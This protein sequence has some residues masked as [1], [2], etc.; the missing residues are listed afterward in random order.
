MDLFSPDPAANFLPHDGVVNDYGRLLDG[1]DADFYFDRLF[2]TIPW[3]HDE[4]V[5]FGK[6]IVTARKVAWYGDANFS[7]TYSGRTKHALPW[8]V[9]LTQ[10]K[11]LVE[12]RTGIAYNSC[13]L[14]LY[15]DGNEG[16][17]WHS[18][19]E[20]S[21]KRGSGIASL[22]FGAE[23]KFSFRHKITKETLSLIL[24]HGALLVMKGE[25]QTHWHHCIPKSKK[26]LT[27]RIN[28]TFRSMAGS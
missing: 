14:N 3:Q 15:H 22:S 19:D 25:T 26:V 20:R 10:L 9:E 18:D 5:I 12:D 23:R 4:A 8:I 2:K 24:G 16:M 13:L 1:S 11:Q 17:A 21:L 28:L 27:P 6:H 7:Y